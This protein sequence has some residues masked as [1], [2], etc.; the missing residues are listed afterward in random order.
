MAAAVPDARVA[1]L[2]GQAHAA[3]MFA[4]QVVAEA[5]LDLLREQR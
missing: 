2:E 4:P 3:E 1:T 5:M